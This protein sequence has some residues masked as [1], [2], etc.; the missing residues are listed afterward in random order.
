M[1]PLPHAPLRV[2]GALAV[3]LL[4]LAAP[5]LAVAAPARFDTGL[6]DPLDPGFEDPDTAHALEV[7]QAE[8][9]GVIRVPVAWSSIAPSK[10]KNPGDPD[11]PAYQ[12][13]WL[14]A[15]VA[16]IEALGMQPLL[17][18]YGAPGWARAG[19]DLTPRA[20]TFGPFAAAAA[21]RYDG[22]NHP[23]VRLWQAWSEPN[24]HLYFK[25]EPAAARRY[26]A[27]V[28]SAYGPIHAAASGNVVVAG[29]LAPLGDPARRTSIAPMA[30]MRD[31]LCM[32][33]GRHPHP[34]CH[35]GASFDVWSQHPYTT[36]GPNTHAP[37]DDVFVA[38]LPDMRRLLSA[39]HRAGHVRSAGKPRFWITEFSWDTKP[40]DPGGLPLHTQAR[41]A[42]EAFYRMWT[43]GVSLVSW[44]QLRDAPENGLGWGN[45]FQGGLYGRTRKLYSDE[46][47]KP[48]AQVLRFP[49]AALPAGRRVVVWGR[50]PDGRR[51]PVLVERRAGGRWR[52]VAVLQANAHGVFHARRSG[53]RGA[54]VRARVGSSS[55]LPFRAVP[56][57]D[58]RVA[59]FGGTG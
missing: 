36:G 23:R 43:S 38:D 30:F 18:L 39:A 25:I 11:D 9:V 33:K 8:R 28:N 3:A 44:F 1:P 29:G 21:H 51:H 15:R 59:P 42:A 37:S 2:I 26:R 47:A 40:P 55:A 49:F 48:V 53:L 32:S 50:T 19:D 13:G 56:T 6:Q 57:H 58:R 7:A 24:L 41:W 52:R 54:L 14:D 17:V 22:S 16:S 4:V 12:W 20:G 10:P 35:Q 5:A 27:L 45:T 31:M 34:T 46:P